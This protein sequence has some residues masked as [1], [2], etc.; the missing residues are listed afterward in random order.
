MIKLFRKKQIVVVEG[1][2]SDE[3]LAFLAE[4]VSELKK[5]DTVVEVGSHRGRSAIAMGKVAQ[6]NGARVYAIDPHLPFVG[7][8]GREFGPADLDYM[9]RALVENGVGESVFVVSLQSTQ[10]ARAW[11]DSSVSLLF[12]D[13]DHSA[14]A[15]RADVEAWS[16]KIRIGG[17]IA[18]HDSYLDG[19]KACIDK[20]ISSELWSRV[21][22]VGSIVAIR[23]NDG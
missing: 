12:L 10:A 20:L 4:C 18:F 11:D 14:E 5:D 2:T 1:S 9:Y 7:V 3:E 8:N 16:S 23:R 13:G 19:V 22:E 17:V 6:M 21:G 15:V